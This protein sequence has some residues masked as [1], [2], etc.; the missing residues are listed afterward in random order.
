MSDA[1]DKS[2]PRFQTGRVR[3]ALSAVAAIRRLVEERNELRAQ[4]AAQDRELTR[5]RRSLTSIRETYRRLTCDFVRQLQPS[6]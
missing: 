2:D 3:L 6:R 1:A 4:L 5:V